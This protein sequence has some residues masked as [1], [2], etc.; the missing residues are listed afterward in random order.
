MGAGDLLAGEGVD[1]R[2]DAL[3]QP[4][5][6]GED[7]RRSMGVD[8]FQD[9][10]V[11]RRPDRPGADRVG[12]ERVGFGGLVHVRDRHHEFQSSWDAPGASTTVTG[13]SRHSSPSSVPPPRNLAVVPAGVAWRTARSVAAARP[14]S[15]RAVPVS[16]PGGLRVWSRPPRGPRR[17]SPTAP[18]GALPCLAGEQQV[19]RLRCRDEDVGRVALHPSPLDGGG[20]A[21]AQKR[22]RWRWCLEAEALGGVADAGQRCTEVPIDV[23]GERLERRDV[24]DSTART[25]GG[26]RVAEEGIDRGEEGR[27]RLSGSGRGVDERVPSG[28]DGRPAEALGFRRRAERSLEPCSGGG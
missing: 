26:F 1:L 12:I 2:A 19:E 10:W 16:M 25:G 8:Q 18:S 6:V 22:R 27:Q 21:R 3:S 11:D 14:R 20:V 9:P 24:E 17:R 5:R 23:M 4:S 28:R 7:D 13:R 15:L